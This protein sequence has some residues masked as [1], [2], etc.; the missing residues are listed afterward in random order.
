MK[1]ITTL[2]YILEPPNTTPANIPGYCPDET[3]T[4]YG[5]YCY[6]FDPDQFSTWNSAVDDCLRRGGSNASLTII[7]KQPPMIR[8]FLKGR[9]QCFTN[10]HR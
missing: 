9:Q 1:T 3:W 10:Y 2:K 5:V 8:L 6:Y 4:A 7:G